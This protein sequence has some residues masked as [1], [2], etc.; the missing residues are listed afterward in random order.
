MT[1]PFSLAK[2]TELKRLANFTITEEKADIQ[3]PVLSIMSI[4]D[5]KTALHPG[6][7]ISHRN[8]NER[9]SLIVDEGYLYIYKVWRM[10]DYSF[11]AAW[12]I[13]VH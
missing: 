13:H 5:K 4:G 9:R 11:I 2:D 3:F 8:A 12:A 7:V 6:S 10:I 1:S